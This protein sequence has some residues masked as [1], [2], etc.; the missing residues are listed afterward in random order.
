MIEVTNLTKQFGDFAALEN[1][2]CTIQSGCIYGMVGSNGTGK[3]TFLRTLTGVYRPE[4]G[5]I[6]VDGEPV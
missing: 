6:L 4:R 1:I 3:S 2:I 5:T